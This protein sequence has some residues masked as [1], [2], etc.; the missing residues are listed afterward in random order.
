MYS[1]RLDP[2]LHYK[3]VDGPIVALVAGMVLVAIAAIV[4]SFQMTG[5][6]AAGAAGVAMLLTALGTALP[7]PFLVVGLFG[8]VGASVA[9]GAIIAVRAGQRIGI[10]VVLGSVL[11]TGI[12]TEDGRA[13]LTIPLA[14]AWILVGLAD[15]RPGRAR[16][17]GPALGDP[18]TP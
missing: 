6:G 5:A 10:P 13:L 3:I 16:D 12:N 4:R 18:S 7:W 8:F 11:L 17:G 2:D 9:F 1:T 15:L 14:V